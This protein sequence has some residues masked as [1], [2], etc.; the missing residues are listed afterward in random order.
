MSDIRRQTRGQLTSAQRAAPLL[1]TID[2]GFVNHRRIQT[3]I[4]RRAML[5][6]DKCISDLPPLQNW[7]RK[8]RVDH[9]YTEAIVKFCGYIGVRPLGEI[10]PSAAPGQLFCSTENVGPF[11]D[12]YDAERA[13]NVWQPHG[14]YDRKIEFHYS[15][16]HIFADTLKSELRR[17]EAVSAIGEIHDV[18]GDLVIAWPIVMGSPWLQR[19]EV[20]LG[21][22]T[23]WHHWD[24][25]EHFVEDIDEFIKVQGFAEPQNPEPMRRVSERAF[26]ACLVKLLGDAPSPDWGG[27]ASDYFTSHLHINGQRMTAAFLLKGPAR[28]APMGLNHLGK[29]NDQILRLSKTPATCLLCNTV[30]I[31]SLK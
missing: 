29:N 19:G 4:G 23:M 16:R 26:K 9:I 13:I 25:G 5:F 3:I 6:V 12:I 24:F 17:G 21:F 11:P 1:Y 2:P 20:E 14:D 28:F 8:V 22:A 7:E 15:T 30:M 10:V 18:V 31:F 27:E